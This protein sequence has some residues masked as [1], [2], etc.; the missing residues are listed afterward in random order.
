MIDMHCRPPVPTILGQAIWGSAKMARSRRLR[1]YTGDVA[2]STTQLQTRLRDVGVTESVVLFEP[3]HG[4]SARD[5]HAQVRHEIP[6]G[7]RGAFRPAAA[8]D[9]TRIDS[10]LTSIAEAAVPVVYVR[11]GPVP[12]LGAAHAVAEAFAALCEWA[13]ETTT[14]LAIMIGGSAAP[15]LDVDACRNLDEWAMAFDRTRFVVVHGG[16]PRFDEALAV[17][18]RR[19]NVWLVPDMYFPDFP[20]AY[21][22]QLALDGFARE[23]IL[24]GSCYP[25]VD[26]AEHLNRT[27]D[28]VRSESAWR[29]YTVDNAA[30]L[31]GSSTRS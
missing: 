4:K 23:R 19:G 11:P 3:V 27:R 20:G 14:L 28:V 26:V 12:R 30:A 5:L 22:L 29:S 1:G 6:D 13:A 2:T 24:Y 10:D 31:L 7:A 18:M 8:V 9:L 17:V 15:T 21:D 16:F 25:Y